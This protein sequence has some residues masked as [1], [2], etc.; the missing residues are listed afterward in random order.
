[1][2]NCLHYQCS[3]LYA[4]YFS[5]CLDEHQNSFRYSIMFLAG[6]STTTCISSMSCKQKK[7][8]VIVRI[9]T[10]TYIFHMMHDHGFCLLTWH[11]ISMWVVNGPYLTHNSQTYS[12][13]L[14]S[15]SISSDLG[16]L[17]GLIHCLLYEN[18]CCRVCSGQIVHIIT[19]HLE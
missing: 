2:Y 14:S 12:C 10:I 19:L 11:L 15:L 17:S 4:I 3:D 9:I 18:D 8:F 5:V 7:L 6:N 1:M 16:P 13:F